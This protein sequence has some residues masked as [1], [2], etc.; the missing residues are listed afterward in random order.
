[1]PTDLSE[2]LDVDHLICT[3]EFGPIREWLTEQ[4][5]QYGQRYRADE[6]IERATGEPLTAEY[7]VEYACE[8]YTDLYDL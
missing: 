5:H 2:D 3:G 4:V 7:F 1:M 8:K 6:L